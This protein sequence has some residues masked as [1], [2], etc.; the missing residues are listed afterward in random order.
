MGR[1][2]WPQR[3][4]RQSLSTCVAFNYCQ[5]AN[6]IWLVVMTT[7]RYCRSCILYVNPCDFSPLMIRYTD[8]LD[9]TSTV[10]IIACCSSHIFF[11]AIGKNPMR[12][13]ETKDILRRSLNDESIKHIQYSCNFWIDVCQRNWHKIRDLATW[14]VMSNNT[15]YLQLLYDR[16]L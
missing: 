11:G 8:I 3:R 5:L 4:G 7:A 14:R 1:C 13:N 6:V 10:E 9:N 15:S 2:D 16:L 12:N